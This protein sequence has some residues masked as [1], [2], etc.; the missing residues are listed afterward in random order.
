MLWLLY[1]QNSLESHGDL[2]L[3]VHDSKPALSLDGEKQKAF[4]KPGHVRHCFDYLRQSIMCAADSNIEPVDKKLG[5]VTGWGSVRV[6]RSFDTLV[7]WA[8]EHSSGGKT[9]I[10]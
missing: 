1:Y 3:S 8:S 2:V 4:L 7:A 10:L 5:G 6:C 9:S